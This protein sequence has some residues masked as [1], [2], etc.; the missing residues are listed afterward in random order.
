MQPTQPAGDGTTPASS[1]FL[2]P[3]SQAGIIEFHRQ[4]YQQ[5]NQ[6]WNI[7]AQMREIDLAYNRELDWTVENQRAKLANRLGDADRLQDIQVPLVMPQIEAMVAYQTSVF[8]TGVP[9]FGVVAGAADEDTARQLETVIDNNATRGGWAR[10]FMMFF[11]DGFKYN[12]GCVEVSWEKEITAAFETDPTFAG[13]QQGK[14]VN[15]VWE[16]NKIKRLDIYN[17]FWDSR[18]PVTEH[19]QRGE[20][21][22]Y[23]RLMSRMELKMFLA[24]LP[25]RM[26]VTDAFNSGLGSAVGGFS[27]G[28]I[29]SYYIPQVNPNALINRNPRQSLDW[30]AW[31]GIAGSGNTNI[32]YKNMYEV[33]TLYGRIL[34]S[35]FGLK[36]P[37]ANTPQIWKFHI[38]NHQ[39]IIYA[40]RLTNAHGYLPLLFCQPMEDGLMYQTKSAADNVAPMQKVQSAL[41]NSIIASRRRAI[42]DRVLYDPSR[43]TEKQI[44][45]PNPSAK[46]PVRPSAYGKPVGDAV[47][48]FPYRED[49][50]SV[51]FQTI[52]QISQFANFIT[53]Q[54]Q[55]KQGQFVK[56]NKTLHEYADV[57]NNANSRD[58]MVSILLEAQVFTPMKHILKQD[59]LQYQGGVSL[60]SQATQEQVQIDPVALRKAV[61]NFKVSDGLTPSDKLIG[62]DAFQTSLQVL[63]SSQQ[64]S[65][66]Y[67][68]APLFSYLMKTQHADLTP[69][70]KSP[71][72]VAY[73]QAMAQW[74]QLAQQ[75]AQSGGDTSKLPPQPTPQAYGYN[76]QQDGS[77]AAATPVAKT[78]VTNKITNP[79]SP[80]LL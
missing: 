45:N 21:G 38:V 10:E 1:F 2:P 41:M 69:F 62:A 18:V 36:V 44:N 30:M 23:T 40:E 7:R 37:A 39:V 12:V 68:I 28:G 74:S 60:L 25:S 26:N 34:P 55:A 46:I 78:E 31:A 67:N 64:I 16:G 3:K 76:P 24:S 47:Y 32:Q 56:G 9:L 58:Q 13:G 4:A 17:T 19:Y 75:V 61:M 6:Q 77:P 70:E 59:V 27:T 48:A 53:G 65:Q 51:N 42:S 57:M 66:E 72:Q 14:P 54:N 5:L 71:A 11:R 20:F 8:L 63:G 79:Q 29:E 80:T 35:D 50:A 52:Q 73:E 22:G 33:T 43:V 49:Q 15:V